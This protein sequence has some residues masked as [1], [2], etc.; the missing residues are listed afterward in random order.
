[1]RQ[2]R[3]GVDRSLDGGVR[4]VRR[5]RRVRRLLREL[6][7]LDNHF[8]VVLL[9]PARLVVAPP[10]RPLILALQAEVSARR[11][12][13]RSFVTLFPPQPAGVAS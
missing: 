4:C 2:A 12:H 8:D 11:A 10:H 13:G 5:V 1:M 9:L 3:W 7:A 6:L